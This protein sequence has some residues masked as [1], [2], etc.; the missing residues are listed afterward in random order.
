MTAQPA[1]EFDRT[2]DEQ[3]AKVAPLAGG[4]ARRAGTRRRAGPVR[5]ELAEGPIEERVSA[6]LGRDVRIAGDLDVDLSLQPRITV[7]DVR[8]A[9]PPWASD[10]PML[11]LA[12]A[13]AVLDL[14]ALI[15]GEVRL[16][17]VASPSRRC[18]W[19]PG[20]TA[21]RTGSS[22]RG[23]CARAARCPQIGR[24]RI[25]CRGPLSRARQRPV[26]RRA[27]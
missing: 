26:G 4:R 16:P 19:R 9:N 2:S 24:L 22:E 7:T 11:A 3:A 5:L 21:R 8:L 13:E 10:E 20:R 6:E 12:R 27:S 15:D 17:E 18:G 23:A 1:P 25:A 14:R